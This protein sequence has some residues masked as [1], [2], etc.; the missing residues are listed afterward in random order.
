MLRRA[1]LG[2]DVGGTSAKVALIREDGRIMVRRRFLTG[3][4]LSLDLFLETVAF[5]AGILGR[6]AEAQGLHLEGIALGIPGLV[7]PEGV[8]HAVVNLPFLSEHNLSLLLEQKLLLPVQ[9][10]NDA[11]AA[12]YGEFVYGAGRR[13][14]SIL[15]MTLGTGVGG[16]LV[17]N[18]SLWTGIDGVAG[19]VG[20]VTVQPDGRLCSCGN[21]GCLEQYASATAVGQAWLEILGTPV[22]P[23]AS[24]AEAAK[25]AADAA[26]GGDRRARAL[27]EEAGRYLGIA[28]ASIA[29]LLNIEAVVLGGGLAGSIDLLQESMSREIRRRAFAIHA[30]RMVILAG[31]LA[32][33]AGV[34][35]VVAYRW[36][37]AAQIGIVEEK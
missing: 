14:A 11:N 21:Y 34:L 22:P 2:I 37:A 13:F 16:G 18:G 23:G 5:E 9:L 7:S 12:A 30:D 1:Y 26:R 4:D 17:L 24:T 19:E 33:D 10:L 29:N 32:D 8:P 6:E 28:A 27:F 3:R 31:E 36:S 35:G 20:H 15:M 25:P